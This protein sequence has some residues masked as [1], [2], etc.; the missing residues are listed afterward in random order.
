MCSPAFIKYF[1]NLKK[2]KPVKLKNIPPFINDYSATDGYKAIFVTVLCRKQ[3]VINHF[4]N[5]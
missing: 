2:H 5:G 1:K 3:I 4:R